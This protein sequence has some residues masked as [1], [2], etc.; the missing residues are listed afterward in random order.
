LIL[1]KLDGDRI[2]FLSLI[3]GILGVVVGLVSAVAA[4][5][6]AFYAKKAA[7]KDNLT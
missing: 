4:I 1:I 6:A 7:T 3:A 5:V 2:A